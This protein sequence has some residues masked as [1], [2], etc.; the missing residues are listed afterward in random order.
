MG[1]SETT[2]V[3]HRIPMRR[4]LQML[5]V[6]FLAIILLMP[7]SRVSAAS[8][9]GLSAKTAKITAGKTKQL[10]LKKGTKKITKGIKWKTSDKTIVGVTQ[11]GKIK[12]KSIGK[13]K[14]TAVYKNKRYVCKVTVK[15]P[16]YKIS[17]KKKTLTAGKT[18]QL[19]LMN[20]TKKVTTGIT[21]QSDKKS[22]ATV[23][24]KGK[25]TAKKAGTATITA[26]NY[27]K[28]YSCKI[29]VKAAAASSETGTTTTTPASTF[30]FAKDCKITTG[31]TTIYVEFKINEAS[32]TAAELQELGYDVSGGVASKETVCETA[33]YTFTKLPTTYKD[34][35]KIPLNTKFAPVAAEIVT[36]PLFEYMSVA[37]GMY[38]HPIF[39]TMDY[40]N[41]EVLSISNGAKSDIYLSMR[42]TL[43]YGKYAYF[44]GATPANAYTPTKPYTFTL[45]EGP[46]EVPAKTSWPGS[47]NGAPKRSMILISFGGDDEQRYVDTYHS[48]DGNWYIFDKSWQ[49][50]IASMK[51]VST[52]TW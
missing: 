44:K 19:N 24:K 8:K 25:V 29:T 50:L 48:S 42:D 52:S 38:S 39:D 35:E 14:I 49:H 9:I 27:G 21:W 5:C 18:F 47:P 41:G 10:A 40:L 22:V 33:T 16:N 15:A 7:A 11:K 3:R 43:T 1:K 51:D 36:L 4:K 13:A 28:V 30:D 6:L 45:I 26:T 34:I 2:Q 23:S 12:G 32:V 46:Y 20:G 37:D 17:A 31:S